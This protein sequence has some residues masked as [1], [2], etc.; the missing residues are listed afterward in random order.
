[1]NCVPQINGIPLAR[2]VSIGYFL[3]SI[4]SLLLLF[5]YFEIVSYTMKEFLNVS[6]FVSMVYGV[7]LIVLGILVIVFEVPLAKRNSES[8]WDRLS[9][10]QKN[11]FD[12]KSTQLRNAR[13]RNSFYVASFAI[14][15][16]VFFLIVGVGMFLLNRDLQQKH[17]RG[18]SSRLPDIEMHECVVFEGFTTL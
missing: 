6:R 7:L 4:L 10:N 11:F 16:G 14:V 3:Q 17:V 8:I 2:T 1:M 9:E 12:D 13:V 15:I 5:F 18:T